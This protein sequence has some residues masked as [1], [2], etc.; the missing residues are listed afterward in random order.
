MADGH[1]VYQGPAK[2]SAAH[3]AKLDNREARRFGNPADTFM[4][5][6]SINYPKTEKDEAN[7]ANWI[8]LYSK[9]CE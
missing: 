5:I 2:Q 6:T 4:R 9:H 3:F 7:I 8:N 1:I